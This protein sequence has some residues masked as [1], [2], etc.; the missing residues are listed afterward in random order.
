MEAPSITRTATLLL[1][2]EELEDH[3]LHAVVAR[4]QG[5]LL[6]RPALSDSAL[7]VEI[8]DRQEGC[9][10]ALYRELAPVAQRRLVDQARQLGRARGQKH[11][12]HPWLDLTPA[13]T[14]EATGTPRRTREHG[15][16]T[17]P[18]ASPSHVPNAESGRA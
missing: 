13:D 11:Q 6:D 18:V 4:A 10:L 1:T 12:D 15:R 9:L 16:R 14:R 17:A 8:V 2:L 5:L 7:A 3:D